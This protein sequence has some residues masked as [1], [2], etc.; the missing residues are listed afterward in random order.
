MSSSGSRQQPTGSA[1]LSRKRWTQEENRNI[2]RA[3]FRA[4][5]CETDNVRYRQ[6]FFTEWK[7]IY[8]D[9]TVSEQ[10]I[11]DQK[12]Q[13]VKKNKFIDKTEIERIKEQIANEMNI[14]LRNDYEVENLEPVQHENNEF[15]ENEVQPLDRVISQNEV[16]SQNVDDINRDVELKF[17]TLMDK[18]KNILPNN[19]PVIPKIKYDRRSEMQSKIESKNNGHTC[20][21]FFALAC[22][23]PLGPLIIC[24][25]DLDK[26]SQTKGHF[27]II[28]R[29]FP[30]GGEKTPIVEGCALCTFLSRRSRPLLCLYLC[31]LLYRRSEGKIA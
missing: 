17:D 29:T 11:C 19:R 9:T 1:G 8:P 16:I 18:Y 25:E 5:K 14:T 31:E 23:S 13:M 12:F 15:I 28:S 21:K 6:K 7:K 4:T 10:R 24:D 3:Y 20:P 26:G 22:I 2:F 30:W 27:C